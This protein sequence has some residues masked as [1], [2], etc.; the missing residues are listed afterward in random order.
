[1][2]SPARGIAAGTA[3]GSPCGVVVTGVVG[4]ACG[5]A[6]CA[7]RVAGACCELACEEKLSATAPKITTKKGAQIRI[8]FRT[9]ARWL[10][11]SICPT[12]SSIPNLMANPR[13]PNPSLYE[14]GTVRRTA[15]LR[16][17]LA[18]LPLPIACFFLSPGPLQRTCPNYPCG[19]VCGGCCF[20]CS[21]RDARKP[22]TL[23][24][25][26]SRCSGVKSFA[27]CMRA[28]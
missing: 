5:A 4:G 3:C 18:A 2:L 20:R 14:K 6:D 26:C 9:K 22:R 12:S 7:A 28:L 15:P 1:M 19:W 8:Y 17:T 27:I 13:C 24:R 16:E 25:I 11:R 21:R 23:A 10:I